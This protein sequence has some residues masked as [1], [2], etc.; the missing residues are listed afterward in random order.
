MALKCP[1]RSTI[2]GMRKIS[3]FKS[4]SGPALF[5]QE[6]GRVLSRRWDRAGA[7]T[8]YIHSLALAISVSASASAAPPPPASASACQPAS[9]ANSGPNGRQ[10][11]DREVC[12]WLHQICVWDNLSPSLHSYNA[13]GVFISIYQHISSSGCVPGCMYAS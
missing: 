10:R 13:S 9:S 7:Q 4:I 3:V 12:E 2:L 6:M 5:A 1:C 8:A 11:R